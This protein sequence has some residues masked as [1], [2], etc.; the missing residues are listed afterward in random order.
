MIKSY[1]ERELIEMSV[2]GCLRFKPDNISDD[3]VGGYVVNH[4]LPS[5]ELYAFVDQ[6]T[7]DEISLFI[8]VMKEHVTSLPKETVYPLLKDFREL[9]R[10]ERFFIGSVA[11]SMDRLLSS[12]IKSEV[13]QL[14][15]VALLSHSKKLCFQ[16]IKLNHPHDTIYFTED[17]IKFENQ[18][19]STH[20]KMNYN[21]TPFQKYAIP[22]IHFYLYHD[23]LHYSIRGVGKPTEMKKIKFDY[24]NENIAYEMASAMIVPYLVER[25]FS[26]EDINEHNIMDFCLLLDMIAI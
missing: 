25:G 12:F 21:V 2:D 20:I 3:D 10:K 23:E 1:I 19:V 18:P 8:R 11:K 17:L 13:G 7:E 22:N 4:K 24:E 26:V 14:S 9:N 15:E 6:F 16:H 5:S